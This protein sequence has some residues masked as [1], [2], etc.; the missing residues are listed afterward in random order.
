MLKWLQKLIQRA[1]KE[2]LSIITIILLVVYV[3]IS[4]RTYVIQQTRLEID[5][6]T[7]QL[8]LHLEENLELHQENL[9]LQQK[10]LESL[11]NQNQIYT[12]N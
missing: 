4:Y 11:K 2:A 7:Y 6:T 8:T 1:R 3:F 5:R 9:E 10:N 12:I